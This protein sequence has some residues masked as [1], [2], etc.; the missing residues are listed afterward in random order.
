M[1]LYEAILYLNTLK[2]ISMLF[3]PR[4]APGSN[5]V[6][7]RIGRKS[8]LGGRVEKVLDIT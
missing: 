4:F 3:I 8:V 7:N 2:Y 5:I 6:P 1:E